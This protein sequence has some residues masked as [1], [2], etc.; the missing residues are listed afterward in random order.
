MVPKNFCCGNLVEFFSNEK[1]VIFEKGDFLKGLYL[2][3]IG[4]V[5]VLIEPSN[6]GRVLA[7]KFTVQIVCDAKKRAKKI[8][9]DFTASSRNFHGTQQYHSQTRRTLS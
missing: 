2:S 7:D 3:I 6:L 4:V 8:A 5:V 9:K 1:V